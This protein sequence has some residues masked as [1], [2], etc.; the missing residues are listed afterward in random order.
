M[1][2]GYARVSTQ[3]QHLDRQLAA[4][5][6]AGVE[7]KNVFTDKASGAKADRAALADVLGRLREGDTLVVASFDRLARSTEQLLTLS[8]DL[9]AQGVN[10]VSLKE[11]IDTTTPQGRFFFTVTA[12]VAEFERELIKERQREGIATARAKGVKFGRPATDA[13]AMDTATRLYA[14]GGVSVAGICERTG[15]SRAALYR[16]I[17]AEGVTRTA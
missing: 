8:N 11:Q 10:L 16:K 12:A 1:K 13:E 15:V 7:P 2:F 4:L 6:A 5:D 14:A 3:E 9:A 17:K